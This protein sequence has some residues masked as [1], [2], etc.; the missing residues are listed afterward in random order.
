ML[1]YAVSEFGEEEKKKKMTRSGRKHKSTLVTEIR[2]EAMCGLRRKLKQEPKKAYVHACTAL[3]VCYMVL[4]CHEVRS[5]LPVL[6]L[7]VL[8][9][10]Q[11]SYI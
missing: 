8:G 11:R 2:L 6:C 3:L 5:L 7:L 9:F 4:V 10:C 1:A